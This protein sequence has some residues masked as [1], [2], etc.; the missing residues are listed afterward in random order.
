M[1]W[2]TVEISDQCRLICPDYYSN[3]E[4]LHRPAT[5]AGHLEHARFLSLHKKT[6]IVTVTSH[7][8]HGCVTHFKV[9]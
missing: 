2:I 9:E 4:D 8:S 7:C 6:F 1:T 5:F 3:G